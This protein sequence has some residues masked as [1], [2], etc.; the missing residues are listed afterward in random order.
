M[1]EEKQPQNQERSSEKLQ[2]LHLV[3]KIGGKPII[4]AIGNKS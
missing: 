4:D 1:K 2:N 3:S